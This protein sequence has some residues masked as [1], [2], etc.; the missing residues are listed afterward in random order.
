M[1]SIDYKWY[2]AGVGII[3]LGACFSIATLLLTHGDTPKNEG[4]PRIVTE[5]APSPSEEKPSAQYSVAATQP[6]SIAI[7][8]LGITGFIQQVGI[9]PSGE[10]TAPNNIHMAG[11]FKESVLPGKKGLSIIDGHEGGPTMD[12]IFKKLSDITTGDQIIITMGDQTEH[13]YQVF[14]THT[15]AEEVSA[16]V[17]F[18]Q[19]PLS[20][21]GQLNLITCTGFFDE[22][23]QTYNKRVIVYAKR[24]V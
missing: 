11:W 23:T 20:E 15:L 1:A 24:I 12:G 7:P 13:A 18:N 22:K 16:Q 17:L 5:S 14:D 10:V 19:S 9:D 6:L 3:A 8:K 21:D 4:T 2:K